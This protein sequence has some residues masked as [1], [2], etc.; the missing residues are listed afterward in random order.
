M[1][2]FRNKLK[3]GVSIGAQKSFADDFNKVLEILEHMEGVAGI[4]ITKKGTDWRFSLSGEGQASGGGGG[5][6]GIPDGYEEE[7][8]NV[9]TSAGILTR[10][11][12]VKT[13]TKDDYVTPGSGNKR[14]VLQVTEPST[15]SFAIGLDY[16]HLADGAS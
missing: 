6:G 7:T 9:V 2:H 5:G 1:N 4:T 12:L 13:S 16:A 8:L 11:V 15:G 10:T 14:F 3:K